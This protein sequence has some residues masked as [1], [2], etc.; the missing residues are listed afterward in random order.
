MAGMP[1]MPP[2]RDLHASN[3]EA[4]ALTELW[5]ERW[6]NSR[7]IAHELKTSEHNRWVRF[8]SLP[9]S[10]RYADTEAEYQE[11]LHR[12]ATVLRELNGLGGYLTTDVRD[13]L[14]VTCSW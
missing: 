4:R 11:I 5:R 12:H 2:R 14:V 1:Q 9:D 10:K 7:P 3:S 13:L 8:H 6:P